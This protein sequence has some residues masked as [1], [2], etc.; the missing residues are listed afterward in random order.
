MNKYPWSSHKAYLAQAKKWDWVHKK[1]IIFLYSRE[2]G[3]S[4]FDGPDAWKTSCKS[5]KTEGIDDV[6][7]K[8]CYKVVLTPH[9]LSQRL[10]YFDKESF[11]AVKYVMEVKNPSGT[12]KLDAFLEDYRKA[13]DILSPH[14]INYFLMGQLVQIITFE[15]IENNIDMPEGIFDIPEQKKA[16]MKV[17]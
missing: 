5:V 3:G 12:F 11:L 4:E 14:K 9:E 8:A 7:G 10:L 17:L 6:N 1:Y 13:G 16:I 15:S 2:K